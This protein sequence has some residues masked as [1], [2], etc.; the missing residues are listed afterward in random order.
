MKT[1]YLFQP[2]YVARRIAYKF[3]EL[4][5]PDEPWIA[6]GAIR[7]C[8]KNLTKEQVGLEWGSGRST[9]WFGSHLKS[10]LSIEYDRSWH[11]TVIQQLQKKG[12]KNVECRHITLEHEPND[13]TYTHYE[14]IPKYVS[15][16]E[17][18]EDESIDFVV[19]DG[20]YRQACVLAALAKIKS[21]GFLLVD[22]TNRVPIEEWGV[23]SDWSIVHQSSNVMTQT[24]IWKKP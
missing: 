13:P 16:V 24:T 12:I 15:V 7:F 6:Q 1:S 20:H 23:P 19:V 3:Y 18:F 2:I 10:L 22:N 17:E 8:E 14:K 4:S 5:H 21:G 11:F 9:A